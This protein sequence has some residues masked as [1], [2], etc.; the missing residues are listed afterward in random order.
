[1]NNYMKTI[2]TILA[3]LGL[4]GLVAVEGDTTA[5]TLAVKAASILLLLPAGIHEIRNNEK[6]GRA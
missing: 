4:A 3:A 6:E 1:M 2:C 5:S